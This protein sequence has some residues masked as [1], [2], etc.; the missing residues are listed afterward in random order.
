MKYINKKLIKGQE[1]YY[2]EYYFKLKEE[3]QKFTR[4]L[5]TTLPNNLP[6]VLQHYFVEIAELVSGNLNQNYFF[7]GTLKHIELARFHYHLLN[8]KLFEKDLK[9]F[10]TL[11]YI[12]FV[13]NSNRSEGSKVTQPDIEKIITRKINPKSI[14]DREIINSIQAINFAFSKNM[15]WNSKSIKKIHHL[16]FDNI[17]P[18]IAGEY[19]KV[20][21]IV[22]NSPTTEWKHVPKEITQLLNWLKN[23]KRK[24]YPPQLALEFHWRFEEIHPFED[25][26]GRVGRILLNSLLVE[27]GYAPVIYFTDNHSSYCQ[28]LT[29]ARSGNSRPLTKHYVLSIKKSEKAIKQYQERKIIQGG[30]AQVGKWEIQKGKIR[31]S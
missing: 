13:L 28:A 18:G 24:M 25:G 10:K 21:N 12:L 3:K 8:H 7:P 6:Q 9:L 15:K 1:Y 22:G 4:Y 27:F 23:N 11:F 19:K 14:I 30:S 20:N 16:L 17:Y 5:G 2:F 26:N 29:K 31:L